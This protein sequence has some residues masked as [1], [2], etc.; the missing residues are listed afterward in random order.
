MKHQYCSTNR[1]DSKPGIGL[2][3]SAV[4]A[5]VRA[6]ER[7]AVIRQLKAFNDQMLRDIGVH[8]RQIRL[9]V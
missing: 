8:R 4:Q 1:A 5:V 2:I 6:Y 7:R 3:R 9:A